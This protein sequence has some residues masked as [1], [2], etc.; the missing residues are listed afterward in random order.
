MTQR[1]KLIELLKKS[2]VNL[3]DFQAEVASNT[4]LANGVVVLPCKEGDTVYILNRNRTRV[5]KMIGE[6]ADIRCVCSEEDN[7]CMATCR[8]AKNGVC[9]YRF[10]NDLS[11]FSKTVFLTREEAE[12]ALKKMEGEK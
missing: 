9:S 10:K 7:L 8:D 1:E 2:L 12:A 4:L 3:S 5:Q 6:A 11:D